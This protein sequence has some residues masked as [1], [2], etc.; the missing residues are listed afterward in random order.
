MPAVVYHPLTISCIGHS[1]NDIRTLK[2]KW[3]EFTEVTNGIMFT[4]NLNKIDSE[5]RHEI[6]VMHV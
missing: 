1:N 5:E 4:L 6:Y 2:N 3:Y